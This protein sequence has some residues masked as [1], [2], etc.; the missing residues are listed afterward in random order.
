MKFKILEKSGELIYESTSFK[1]QEFE[2]QKD[3]ALTFLDSK[4]NLYDPDSVIPNLVVEIWEDN[5]N[6]LVRQI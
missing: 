1:M 4:Y 6:K 5:G 3:L 2:E